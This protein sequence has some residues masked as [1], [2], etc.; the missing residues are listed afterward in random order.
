MV[1]AAGSRGHI[2]EV[3]SVA[4]VRRRPEDTILHDPLTGFLFP[5]SRFRFSI[6]LTPAATTPP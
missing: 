6:L 5:V 2:R 4:Y 1:C 3:T